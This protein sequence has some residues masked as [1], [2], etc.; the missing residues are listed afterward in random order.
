MSNQNS[1]L[2]QSNL[3]DSPILVKMPASNAQQ[4]QQVTVRSE[5]SFVSGDKYKS[6]STFFQTPIY[7][8]I[9]EANLAYHGDV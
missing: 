2:R 8:Y 3:K 9:K 7:Q 5:K 6:I 4:P 1:E